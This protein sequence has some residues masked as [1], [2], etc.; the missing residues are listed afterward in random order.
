MPI[1]RHPLMPYSQDDRG[2]RRIGIDPAACDRLSESL[3]LLRTRGPQIVK[4]FYSLLFER[5]PGVRAMFPS[6]MTRQQSKLLDSLVMVVEH[7]RDPLRVTA[8]LQ[9]LGRRHHG[10]GA[11]PE[12]YPIVCSILLECMGAELGNAWTSSLESEWSQALLLASQIMIQATRPTDSTC[13]T[14]TRA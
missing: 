7:M 3:A 2:I 10:Y 8:T 14:K 13:Q 9:D 1:S 11:R 5:F 12:H 6:D 4:A